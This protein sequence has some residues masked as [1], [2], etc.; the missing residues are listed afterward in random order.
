MFEVDFGPRHGKQTVA[1]KG[2]DHLNTADR[3]RRLLKDLKEVLKHP[4][5]KMDVYPC[6]QDLG[7]WT[8]IMEGD[9]GTPYAGGTWRL[10]VEFPATYPDTPPKMRFETPVKHCN[11]GKHGRI[12]HSIFDAN[13]VR[14]TSMTRV[15][16]LV[17]GLLLN[18][19]PDDPLDSNLA[20]EFRNDNGVYEMS[21][22]THT[23]SFAKS[24]S[25]ADWKQIL[26]LAESSGEENILPQGSSW[27]VF[28]NTEPKTFDMSLDDL[29][30]TWNLRP[31]NVAE[32]KKIVEN[33]PKCCCGFVEIDLGPGGMQFLFKKRIGEDG[34]FS[35][36]QVLKHFQNFKFRVE[37]KFKKLCVN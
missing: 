35:G 8:V 33:N 25:R 32:A 21:I 24:R 29:N 9:P 22:K 37:T 30:V 27:Q 20:L 14:D 12:C 26:A 34:M 11:V 19:E 3:R 36:F 28:E 16:E 5:P 31:A 6:E 2:M 18:P 10:S 15:L 1:R 23:E 17:Y 4:H 13:W 7:F